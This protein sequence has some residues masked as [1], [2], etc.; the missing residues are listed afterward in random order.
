MEMK[1]KW[2]GSRFAAADPE[3][4][5]REIESLGESCRTGDILEKA[6]DE[7]T[8]LHK[9]FEWNDTVAAHKWRMHTARNICCE[10]VVT[11]VEHQKEGPK[12]FRLIQKTSEGYE[13]MVLIAKS[14]DK[15]EELR[16]RMR[17][18]AIRFVERYEA[19]DDAAAAVAELKKLI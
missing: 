9:C 15:M 8:E 11:V 6:K 1:V 5:Y 3:K 13:P 18:D 10:L 19:L 12:T 4:V 2:K 7:T 16:E 14:P 17:L